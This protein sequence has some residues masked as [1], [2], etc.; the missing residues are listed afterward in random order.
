M[1]LIHLVYDYT[2][3]E[4]IQ[5]IVKEAPDLWSSLFQPKFCKTVVQF[6][7]TIKYHEST[8]LAMTP[9]ST[10]SATQFPNQGFQGQCFQP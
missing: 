3:S 5:L 7:N 2:D 9:P 1:D 4:I 10:N 6:Q 8:L